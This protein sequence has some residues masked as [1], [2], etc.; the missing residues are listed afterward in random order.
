[1]RRVG[2]KKV[3]I[4]HKANVLKL[5]D[6]LFLKSAQDVAQLAFDA[7]AGAVALDPVLQKKL[8][9]REHL[10]TIVHRETKAELQMPP[11]GKLRPQASWDLQMLDDAYQELDQHWPVLVLLPHGP[12]ES[13]L[14]ALTD[15][16]EA[17]AGA[18]RLSNEQQSLYDIARR[19]A[20]AFHGNARSDEA[21]WRR[22]SAGFTAAQHAETHASGGNG[23]QV[24]N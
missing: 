4:G 16:L 11:K 20:E 9:V 24:Y 6:G 18:G 22:L 1:M 2:R 19:L 23:R 7:A 13:V 12:Y 8:H 14:P 17:D 3:T 10:K 15:S 5:T 21:S